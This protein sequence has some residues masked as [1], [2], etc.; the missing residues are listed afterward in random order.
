MAGASDKARYFLEQSIPELQELERKKIF[1][2]VRLVFPSHCKYSLLTRWQAEITSVTKKRSD[3]EH[4]LNARSSTPSDYARYAEYEM[5]LES[6][7]KRRARRM[8]VKAN[9]HAGQRRIFFILDRATRKFHGDIGL[10]MQYIE[11]AKKQKSHKKVS[12]ILTSVLRLHPTKPELW[13]YAANY[14]VEVQGNM[15][16][17]RSYMQRGL[18]FCNRSRKIWLEYAKL[19][20]IYISKIAARRRIL[21][22]D[23]NRHK[24]SLRAYEAAD[25][26]DK[27]TLPVI[28]AEDINPDLQHDNLIDETN[29]ASLSANPALSGAIPIAIFDAAF[30]QFK[31]DT[32]G[33]QF[34]DMTVDFLGLPCLGRITHHVADSLLKMHPQSPVALACH[35]RQPAMSLEPAS[36][37]FPDALESTLDRLSPSIN[38]LPATSGAKDCPHP[39]LTLVSKIIDALSSYLRM[40]H[41][42]SN[43]Q[44][45]LSSI[46]KRLF[47]QY[48]TLIQD[49]GGYGVD[50]VARM[51]EQYQNGILSAQATSL[52]AW[53]LESWPSNANLLAVRDKMLQ[54]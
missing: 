47:R 15:A 9:G 18:R 35:I 37:A 21:G 2:H 11:Y 1:T 45:V 29:L 33:E 17:G 48:R 22:L 12:Q 27:L 36:A 30:E 5:N 3:F 7:R 50:E 52:V 34:F 13:I 28:T 39:R 54:V 40:K 26:A 43:I 53:A 14:A 41:L 8:G 4:K 23:E 49:S 24:H 44:V 42:D 46:V 20:M 32:F 16:E 38:M 6:L 19:E 51:A 31:D 10:W 25:T